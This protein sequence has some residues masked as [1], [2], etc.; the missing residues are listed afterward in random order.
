I[1]EG[2]STTLWM[3]LMAVVAKI[4]ANPMFIYRAA[5]LLTLALNV[6]NSVLVRRLASRAG[7]PLSGLIA[8]AIFGLQ[9]VTI[10]ETI[11][12]MEG[13]VSL[14]LILL[15]ALWFED[16]GAALWKTALAGSLFILTR[17]EAAWLLVP[18]LLLRRR[19]RGMYVVALVWAAVFIGS[20]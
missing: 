6:L 13:P 1:V 16:R 18:I 5:K 8:G 12:G 4:N 7:A 2:Y 17:W 19:E 11:N 9:L 14:T 10:Y 15:L 3:L 20:N